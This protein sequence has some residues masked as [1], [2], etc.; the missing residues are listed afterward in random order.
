MK[1]PKQWW[2]ATGL[3]P[4]GLGLVQ[5][6]SAVASWTMRSSPP[7]PRHCGEVARQGGGS[8]SSPHSR[9]DDEAVGEASTMVLDSDGDAL[10]IHGGAS[11]VLKHEGEERKVRGRVTW[12]E[13]R[14]G[15]AHQKG[16]VVAA[17]VAFPHDSDEVAAPQRSARTR[18][19]G[20]GELVLTT[21]REGKGEVRKG[22]AATGTTRL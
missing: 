15:G 4:S 18:G 6:G 7:R 8:G 16:A 12:P 20:G 13:R 3:R 14:P 2:V 1:N 17:T 11:A 19:H 5:R 9:G 10:A 22:P 21:A